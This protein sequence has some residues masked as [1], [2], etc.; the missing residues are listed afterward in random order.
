MITP[1]KFEISETNHM[2]F[3]LTVQLRYITEID[4]LK[5]YT[6]EGYSTQMM[7]CVLW[8][9]LSLHL[10]KHLLE[11]PD[12]SK[13]LEACVMNSYHCQSQLGLHFLVEKWDIYGAAL[14]GC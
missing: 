14:P 4:Q 5:T 9:S 8:V 2:I 6:V 1:N 12:S 10:L 3:L 11:K 7:R 13:F